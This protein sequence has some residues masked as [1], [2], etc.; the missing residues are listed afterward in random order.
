MR[1]GWVDAEIANDILDSAGHVSKPVVSLSEGVSVRSSAFRFAVVCLAVVA[2]ACSGDGSGGNGGNNS[3]G[4]GDGL[5]GADTVG[6]GGNGPNGGTGGDILGGDGGSSNGNCEPTSCE[7]LGKTCGVV[8]DGCGE[9]LNCGACGDGQV[10]GLTEINVCAGI[11]DICVKL[12]QEAACAG[13][14]CGVEGDGCGGTID[15]GSCPGG[16]TCGLLAAYQCAATP[17]G[18]TTDCAARIPS[19]ASVGATCGKIGNGCGG[20]I[21]CD[22]ESGGCLT[23]YLCG[24]DPAHPQTCAPYDACEPLGAALACTGTCGQVGDGCGGTIDCEVEGLGCTG[25]DTCGGGGVPFECGQD[26]DYSCDPMEDAEACAGKECGYVGDGCGT[27]VDCSFGSGCGANSQCKN[28]QCEAIIPGCTLIAEATACSGKECGLAGDGCGGSYSCGS[29]DGGCPS[30]EECGVSSAYQCDVPPR[31]PNDPA[32]VGLTRG[33]ACAGKECGV[34]Y[35]GCGTAPGDTYQCG[36]LPNGACPTNEFCGARSAY[37]CDPL[38]TPPVCNPNGATCASLGWAC[39]TAVGNC[40]Q[41]INCAAEG[42]TCNA[43]QTCVGG[44]TG[45]TKCESP[46]ANPE[47]E[48]PLCNSV[49]TTCNT[50]KLTGRVIASGQA[51]GNTLNQVRVP[52]A[53]VYILRTNDTTDLPAIGTGLPSSNGLSCDRC[54]DQDLGPVLAGDVTDANGNWELEGNVPVGQEFL[55]VTKVGKFRRAQRMTLPAGA[56]C[57]TTPLATGMSTAGGETAGQGSEYQDNPTRLPRRMNDGLA[58]NIPKMAITT[59]KI[60]AMECV[61]YKMG[62]AQTVFGNFNATPPAAQRIDLYRGA[63]SASPEGASIDVNTPHDAALYNDLSR[64]EKY[65]MV[66]SDCEGTSWDGSGGSFAQR[67][68]GSDASQGGN[69]R[70]YVNRG[71][72]MFLSHLSFSWLHQNGT[73]TYNTNTALATGLGQSSTWNT[74]LSTD[75]TGT[76]RVS[77]VGGRSNVSPRIETFADWMVNEGVTSAATTPLSYTFSINQPRSQNLTIVAGTEEFVHRTDGNQRIQQFSFNTPFGAPDSAACGRVAYSGFHVVAG[78]GDSPYQTSIF[79]QHCTG[80]LSAQEKILL[81]ML[82]DLGTCVGEEPEPPECTPVEC[83]TG[84]CGV[85]PNG[86]GGTQNCGGC[87]AGQVCDDNL[88]RVECVKTT[89]AAQGIACST[90]ADGCGGTLECDCNICTPDQQ[91]DVCTVGVCGYQPD[92]CSN[93]IY[94][95]DCPNSCVPE[96]DCPAGVCGTIGNGCDGTITCDPCPTG[97]ICGA[98]GANE[99]GP[100]VCRPLEC[101]ELIDRFGIECGVVGDGCGQ[102]K[103]CGTCPPGQICTVVNGQPNRCAGCVPKTREQACAGLECGAVGDGCGGTIDCGTCPTGEYCGSVSPNR[104]DPGPQCTPQACPSGAECGVVG[105]GCGGTVDC[106]TCPAGQL[107]GVYEPYKCGGCTPQTCQSAG[108]QCGKIGD[109]CGNE[110]DCGQCAPSFICG[111]GRANQCGQLR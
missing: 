3:G 48:C 106:G 59:G 92:G 64:L 78:S 79:P 42:R 82:F 60:D 69:V 39:G 104:C 85:V 33:E 25:E 27:A 95:G 88:C 36:S 103:N 43:T 17:G 44:V 71:G 5:G 80:D 54:E 65:D 81:F 26:G 8:A 45:P 37:Q 24:N 109:G 4:S 76:G 110:L 40:G 84:Q 100:P 89:C 99:C 87:A 108:A 77:L 86:C 49:P 102:T 11:E 105:N 75:N 35:N 7:A 29:N 57:N 74:S 93:V 107:C 32:C 58:V 38:P 34:A 51:D 30:G 6:G 96:T 70:Q 97:E 55:L 22:A 62:L 9:L 18:S 90:I 2:S 101:Y 68:D 20:L 94:C 98:A 53:F 56:A 15:C 31:D 19:C 47:E 41:P 61:F 46:F 111:L 23:G 16:Q 66:V 73:T 67:G 14:Q 21:D 50:T 1:P 12:S 10:C 72:R 28:G 63:S 83:G 13:K 52:N 91:A